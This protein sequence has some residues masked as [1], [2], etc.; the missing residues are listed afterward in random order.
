MAS[1]LD[2]TVGTRFKFKE[3]APVPWAAFH[4]D[5]KDMYVIVSI[6]HTASKM[7]YVVQSADTI[8]MKFRADFTEIGL[9]YSTEDPIMIDVPSLPLSEE[10]FYEELING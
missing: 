2:I 8:S 7:Q 4:L 5:P 10:E 1:S 9:L 3:G 6:D